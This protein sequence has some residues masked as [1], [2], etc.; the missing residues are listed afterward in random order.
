M[1]QTQPTPVPAEVIQP[2]PVPEP[3]PEV[4]EQPSP[5]R[6]IRP[7]K[8]VTTVA[9]APRKQS[10]EEPSPEAAQPTPAPGASSS[11]LA[12]SLEIAS[13]QAK[14][15]LQQERYAKRPKVRRFTSA[16]T[17]KHSEAA[18][19]DNWKRRIEDVGNRNYP[20]EARDRSIYGSLRL[21]VRILPD[22]SVDR[23]ELLQSSGYR[24]LDEAAMRIVRLAAPFQPFPV[25]MRKTTDVL[26]IIRTWKFE[27]QARLY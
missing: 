25:E 1:Q 8:V 6:E 3:A 24:V 10:R 14:L 13:L 21:L 26:E 22:G 17:L 19:F 12:R 9:P 4:A 5:K 11:L 27:N 18:Y 20:S 7:E 15:D 2:A 23:I 16:S